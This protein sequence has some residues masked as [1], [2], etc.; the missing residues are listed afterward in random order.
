MTDVYAA[1]CD[2]PPPPCDEFLCPHRP[3]CADK[4]LACD[5]FVLYVDTGLVR[6]NFDLPSRNGYRSVFVDETGRLY[7][8][9]RQRDVIPKP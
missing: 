5:A 3:L 2:V 6:E 1:R 7:S 8:K 4:R 9:R